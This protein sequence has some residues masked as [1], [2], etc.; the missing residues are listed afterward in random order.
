[1]YLGK[2]IS[3][4][5]WVSVNAGNLVAAQFKQ[6][7]ADVLNST[8]VINVDNNT[9][10]SMLE[11]LQAAS[12]KIEVALKKEDKGIQNPD[13]DNAAATEVVTTMQKIMQGVGETIKWYSNLDKVSN[14]VCDTVVNTANEPAAPDAE[15]AAANTNGGE[16]K[17]AAGTSA[18]EGKEKQPAA[19]TVKLSENDEK[20]RALCSAIRKQFIA[21]GQKDSMGI[22]SE[23]FVKK[24]AP[25]HKTETDALI[26]A[27]HP[28]GQ[29][30]VRQAFYG[31]GDRRN[32][33]INV[34]KSL[35]GYGGKKNLR[36]SFDSFFSKF[37]LN[38]QGVTGNGLH[39]FMVVYDSNAAA[40]EAGKR[41]KKAANK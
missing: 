1:M 19:G 22:Y 23:N 40:I 7:A 24:I 33:N 4:A 30:M 13:K 31:N 11:K 25:N 3:F 41:V 29:E 27:V 20:F 5:E 37:G 10:S 17:P 26:A 34:Q 12:D 36:A 6:K 21:A 8:G 14:A 9:I 16:K 15:N 2:I 18:A 38:L 32:V 35:Q 28:N 39:D